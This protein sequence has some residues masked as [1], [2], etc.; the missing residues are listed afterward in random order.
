M[1]AEINYVQMAV[2]ESGSQAKAAKRLGFRQATISKYVLG[3]VKKMSPDMAKALEREFGY[4]KA[5]MRP[6]VWPTK[7]QQAA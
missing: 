5:E 1:S 7:Q 2:T 4:P 3:K 6:D